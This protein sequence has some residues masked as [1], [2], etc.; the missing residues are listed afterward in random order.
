MTNTIHHRR[1]L[2]LLRLKAKVEKHRRRCLDPVNGYA[3]FFKNV[4]PKSYD[5]ELVFGEYPEQVFQRMQNE[6]WTCDV[7]ARDHMKSTRLYAE[8]MLE[9]FT[10]VENINGRYMSYNDDMSAEHLTNVKDLIRRNP[11]FRHIKDNK[12]QAD[13]VLDYQNGRIRYRCKPSSLL[14]FK[15]GLHPNRLY[16]DDPLRDPENK[17]APLVI[18]KINNIIWTEIIPMVD[19]QRGKCRI[20]GTPQTYEDFYFKEQTAELW[21]IWIQ[22]AI[23][24]EFKKLVLWK[25]RFTWDSL[26]RIMR[27]QGKKKFLQEYRVR[28]AYEV[29]SYIERDDLLQVVNPNLKNLHY[30]NPTEDEE[31]VA[32][33]DIG[34]KRHPAHVAI[35]ARKYHV[36]EPDDDEEGE[37][38]E[39]Y[40]TY[41]Q[42]ASV[43]FDH[44][45]YND[46]V[47][48]VKELINLFEIDIVRYDSTRGELEVL[49]ERKELPPEMKPVT[50]TRKSK[51]SMAT[52]IDSAVTSKRVQLIND[53]RQTEQIL[54]VN[55]NLDAMET[56]LGHGDAFFSNGLALSAK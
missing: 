11:L 35:H 42:L 29:D 52:A 1:Q 38:I 34:K 23:V 3:Y 9:V 12:Q 16:I 7:S 47:D 43:W 6:S 22:D 44:M 24:D 4:F 32:G 27:A 5:H 31:V 2:N 20:V 26:M 18:H 54:S 36:I 13:S 21:S 30:Y 28:P 50:F 49:A 53:T 45:D 51:T 56:E 8:I 15:R 19:R 40:Y 25:E 39:E 46:Q 14:S 17:L 10:G 37:E 41:R 33:Y 48:E 55:S